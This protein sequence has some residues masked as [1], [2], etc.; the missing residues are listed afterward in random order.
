MP[1]IHKENIIATRD[2]SGRRI[3]CNNCMSEE[4][5]QKVARTDIILRGTVEVLYRKGNVIFCDECDTNIY[6]LIIKSDP[7]QAEKAPAP[8]LVEPTDQEI[9]PEELLPEELLPEDLE[10]SL[11]DFDASE[12]QDKQAS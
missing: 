4:D 2:E 11:P 6:R 10:K 5:F 3:L 7:K 9:R 1:I 8:H 12:K